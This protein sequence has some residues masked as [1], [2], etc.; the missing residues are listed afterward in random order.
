MRDSLSRLYWRS[1]TLLSVLRSSPLKSI[2]TAE[3]EP[4]TTSPV[5]NR[6]VGLLALTLSEL[7]QTFRTSRLSYAEYS[8]LMTDG[9]F[10]EL[11][12]S[13]PSPEKLVGCL[14]LYSAIGDTLMR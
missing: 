14:E 1:A 6:S 8:S 3:C 5:Q 10:A 7:V 9:S 13:K 11:T 4:V 2:P 12:W